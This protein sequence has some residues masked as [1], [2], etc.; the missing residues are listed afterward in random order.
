LTRHSGRSG[1][2]HDSDRELVRA[3]GSARGSHEVA[4]TV[5]DAIAH[6]LLDG[7]AG[8]MSTLRTA[9]CTCAATC[10][11]ARPRRT[12]PSRTASRSVPLSDQ[13]A[14]ALDGLSRR[15][16]FG[17]AD[18]L[19]FGSAVG[20][21]LNDDSVRGAFYDALDDAGLGSLRVKGNPSSSTICA[22]RSARSARRTAS[23]W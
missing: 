14:V 17:G 5:D 9:S 3:D 20:G 6:E 21:H 10:P 15:E 13:A 23:T 11:P 2:L 1:I 19:V 18:D 8:G 22:T 4:D 16:H 7:C 12:P